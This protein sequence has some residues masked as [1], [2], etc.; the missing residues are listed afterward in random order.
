MSYLLSQLEGADRR[1]ECER[2]DL[3]LRTMTHAHL[4]Q[5]CNHDCDEGRACPKRYGFPTTR[6]H[7]RS[8]ADAFPDV[9]RQSFEPHEPLPLSQRIALFFR[10]HFA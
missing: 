8:L 5:C 3:A 9:R 2:N 10:R 6:R 4:Q 1:A 7:P